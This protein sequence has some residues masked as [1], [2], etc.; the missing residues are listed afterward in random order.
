[1]DLKVIWTS[2]FL[3]LCVV[4]YLWKESEAFW[5]V[6]PRLACSV[7]LRIYMVTLANC[8]Q[9]AWAYISK[10]FGL[11]RLLNRAEHRRLDW[12][13]V[14]MLYFLVWKMGICFY[15]RNLILWCFFFLNG[16][17]NL[18]LFDKSWTPLWTLLKFHNAS[19]SLVVASIGPADINW[20][21]AHSSEIILKLEWDS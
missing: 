5:Y 3:C 8:N 6:F 10:L 19:W 9:F 20:P 14:S 4:L 1:M 18:V 7:V 21:A 11:C 2:F 15:L 12:K 17:A 16:N 13:S